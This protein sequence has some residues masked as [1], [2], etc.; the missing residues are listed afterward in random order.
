MNIQRKRI[1]W[2][3]TGRNLQ[4]LRN[5]SISLRRFVCRAIRYDEGDCS[6]ECETCRFEMDNSISRTELAKVFAVSESV[7]FNWESGRTPVSLE[8]VLFYCEIAD[9]D[10]KDVIVFEK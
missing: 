3:K 7:I 8:N 10:V 5:D 1:D 6:G 2:E 4:L 9:A